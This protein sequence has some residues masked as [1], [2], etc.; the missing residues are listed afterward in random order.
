MAEYLLLV[1]LSVDMINVLS[2]MLC[3]DRTKVRKMCHAS[4]TFANGHEEHTVLSYWEGNWVGDKATWKKAMKDEAAL[5]KAGSVVA[6][7][8]WGKVKGYC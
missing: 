4:G 5:G 3:D 6:G 8:A 1:K 7:F 2:E